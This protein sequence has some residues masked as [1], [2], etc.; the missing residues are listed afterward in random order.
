MLDDVETEGYIP[1][2]KNR[3]SLTIIKTISANGRPPIPLVI[4][5]PRRKIMESWI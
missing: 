1:S 4:I 3:K 2:P 5:C